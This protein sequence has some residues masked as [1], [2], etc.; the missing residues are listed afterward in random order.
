MLAP[1]VFADAYRWVDADGVV[2]Y[3]DKPHEGAER[4]ELATRATPA[5]QRATTPVAETTTS[6]PAPA[7][8]RQAQPSAEPTAYQSFDIVRPQQGE[9]LWNIGSTMT[10][11]LRLTPALNPS[12]R[13]RLIYDG[14]RRTDLP[15][16]TLDIVLNEVFRGE[17]TLRAQVEDLDGN[18]LIQS[19]ARRFFVQQ[20]VIRRTP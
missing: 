3:S 11:A 8:A 13:V 20:N 14:V 12:H 10:V 6:T 2:H 17:H 18:V 9:T 5:P 1:A 19:N 15:A 4:I 16:D 7:S